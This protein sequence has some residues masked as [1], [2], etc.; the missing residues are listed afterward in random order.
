MY[1]CIHKR[2]GDNLYTITCIQTEMRVFCRYANKE[3]KANSAS[4]GPCN[5]T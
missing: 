5:D 4:A 3:K 1:T 2:G